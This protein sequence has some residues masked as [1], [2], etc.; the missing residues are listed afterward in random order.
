MLRRD[1]YRQTENWQESAKVLQ[2]LAGN[3]PADPAEGIEG[4]PARYVVN[5]AVALYQNNDRDGLRDLVDLWGP[6]MANSSLSGV[7][8][9]IT[10]QE[11]PPTGGDVLQTVDQLIGA[12]RFDNFLTEYRDRLF[13]P[14]EPPN[15]QVSAS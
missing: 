1:I 8:D 5:W 4:Q 15:V 13:A 7:F 6:T 14:P 3:P 9:Y 2:R 11:R 10:N 12:Q